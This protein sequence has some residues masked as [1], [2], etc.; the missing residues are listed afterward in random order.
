MPGG[1]TDQLRKCL[2]FNPGIPELRLSFFFL[3][4]VSFFF[5]A[6]KFHFALDVRV[7]QRMLYCSTFEFAS[8]LLAIVK[9]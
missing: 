8:A 4:F 7:F 9:I 2:V 3:A 5:Y 6:L 1:R